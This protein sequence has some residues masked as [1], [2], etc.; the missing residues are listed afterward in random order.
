MKTFKSFSLI[1]LAAILFVSSCQ[2][3]RTNTG[4]DKDVSQVRFVVQDFVYDGFPESVQTKVDFTI[5]SAGAKFKWSANDTVGIYPSQGSQVYF[6]MNRGAG[7]SSAM[8]TGG[9]WA[10]KG[11]YLYRSYYPFIGDMY[12][13]ATEIPVSYL[14]Q[15]QTGN[16]GTSH[17]GPYDYMAASGTSSESGS[18]VFK[19]K[20][21]ESLIQFRLNTGAGTF[22][23]ITVGIDTAAFIH[24]GFYDLTKDDE[25]VVESGE[26]FKQIELA[27]EDVTV[28]AGDSILTAY[29]MIAPADLAGHKLKIT[30]EGAGEPKVFNIPAKNFKPGYAY[31]I[32]EDDM[33]YVKF[34]D[35]AFKAYILSKVDYNKDGEITVAEARMVDTIY[36]PSNGIW[37][38]KGIEEMPNLLYFRMSGTDPNNKG[39]LTSVDVSNNPLLEVLYCDKNQIQKIDVSSNPNLRILYCGDNSITSIK[40]GDNSKL[41]Y[42]GCSNN[43]LDT[44]ELGN[45]KALERLYCNYNSL[46]S[47]VI[48]KNVN[49]TEVSCTNNL[50]SPSIDISENVKLT[51]FNCTKNYNLYQIIVWPDFDK[52]DVFY[53]PDGTTYVETSNI[54]ELSEG[55]TANCYIVPVNEHYR[56]RFIANVKGN[57]TEALDGTVGSAEVLWESNGRSDVAT[58]DVIDNVTY[59]SGKITFVTKGEGNAV[60]AVK[61]LDGYV[62]WSWHIWVTSYD[63]ATDNETYSGQTRVM[64]NRNLGALSATPGDSLALGLLYQ[65]GRKD[66]FPGAAMID[67]SLSM[68]TTGKFDALKCTS[69]TGTVDYAM[70]YPMRFITSE[71]ESSDWIWG[72][73]IDNLWS[74]TKSKYDPCPAGWRVPD[75]GTS[76]IW[77]NVYRGQYSKDNRGCTISE[78][79]SS[80]VAWYPCG[81]YIDAL[82]GN[83][84]NV[85]TNGHCWSVSV[86]QDFVFT[87]ASEDDGFS[88]I[89]GMLRANALSVRCCS[90]K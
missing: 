23:K 75:G 43:L 46:T 17:I 88:S 1:A 15:K 21:L 28:A 66:P 11:G 37:S 29:M 86:Y 52:A 71:Q 84:I 14:G 19:Y 78:P 83:L 48:N 68:A 56:Y 45:L 22:S 24:E 30:V 2:I 47:L 69:Y 73:K 20:S 16:G 55:G 40:F 65:W 33:Q 63:P 3:D 10:L 42:I 41:T 49:L 58:G 81:G 89:A 62:L 90:E 87:A 77:K 34:E 80:P 59:K 36:V 44:L 51:A 32:C 72:S 4:A 7:T 50:I 74:S 6:C 13:D 79:T 82:E 54:I 27:L 70:R 9:G 5:T 35:E 25:V 18:L 85:G 53:K 67:S 8:F 39:Q 57:S 26:Y 64:M 31:Q 12:L 60:I 61:S 38:V 76:G